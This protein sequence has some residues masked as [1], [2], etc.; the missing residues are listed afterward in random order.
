MAKITVTLYMA[1]TVNHATNNETAK[2]TDNIYLARHTVM[3]REERL[4]REQYHSRRNRETAE[5]RES[6]LEARRACKRHQNIMMSTKQQPR[7][8]QILLQRKRQ[9]RNRSVANT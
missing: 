9:A 4:R 2:I 5:E 3:E 1:G 8:Q 7:Q 6:S